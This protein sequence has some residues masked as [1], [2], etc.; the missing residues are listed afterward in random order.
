MSRNDKLLE[1]FSIELQ[2]RRRARHLSQERL[3][4]EAGVNRTYIAKLE[5][6]KNQPTLCV[7]HDLAKALR[8]S[9]AGLIDGVE[10]RHQLKLPRSEE[11]LSQLLQTGIE[12]PDWASSMVRTMLVKKQHLE[13]QRKEIT[14]MDQPLTTWYCD[15]CKQRIE[16]R[17]EGYVVW[18]SP[19]IKTSPVIKIVHHNRCDVVGENSTAD[20]NDFLGTEGLTHLLSHLSAGPVKAARPESPPLTISGLDPFVDF[21]RR[22]QIPYYEEARLSFNN[23]DFLDKGEGQTE[24]Y[25]PERLTEII[26]ETQIYSMILPTHPE[27]QAL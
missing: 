15:V 18:Q 11:E 22:V 12:D 6:G 13:N 16:D 14:N 20:L 4:Q 2:V 7:L 17:N 21:V 27:A 10:R 23:Q 26:R 19:D 3:A 24:T 5:T 1:A 8:C 25:T 9:L